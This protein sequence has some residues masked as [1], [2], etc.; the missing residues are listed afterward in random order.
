VEV[1][2]EAAP[3]PVTVPLV[4]ARVRPVAVLV[5]LVAVLVPLVVVVALL[6][7]VG[8]PPA[9]LLEVAVPRQSARPALP[10]VQG[11]VAAQA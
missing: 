9:V 7:V 2:K 5:P 3:V 1:G 4:V 10:S 8:V 6:V 11:P